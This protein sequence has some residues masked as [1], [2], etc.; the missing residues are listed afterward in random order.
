M[1]GLAVDVLLLKITISAKM[2]AVTVIGFF[3]F[4]IHAQA[5]S[6]VLF[7]MFVSVWEPAAA[8]RPVNLRIFFFFF[9]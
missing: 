4:N 3:D 1:K 2:N 8:W 7:W 6:H 9:L 5:D